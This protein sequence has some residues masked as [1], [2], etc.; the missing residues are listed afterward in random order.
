MNTIEWIFS[1]NLIPNIFDDEFLSSGVVDFVV[2]GLTGLIEVV[3]V[4]VDVG[5]KV[6]VVVIF[7]GTL[8]LMLI[9]SSVTALLFKWFD[10]ISYKWL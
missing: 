7:T 10:I 1:R 8:F 2:L 6:V 9:I 3:V 4:V 5:K